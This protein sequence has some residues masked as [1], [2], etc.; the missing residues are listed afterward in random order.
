MRVGDSYSGQVFELN[1]DTLPK[2]VPCCEMGLSKTV[3]VPCCEM[4]LSKTVDGALLPGGL[5]LGLKDGNTGPS[6]SAKPK[7]IG[8]T[9][10]TISI[11]DIGPKEMNFLID[12]HS[13]EQK[14]KEGPSFKLYQKQKLALDLLAF[15]DA[16]SSTSGVF[17]G[18]DKDPRPKAPAPTS[19]SSPK[20]LPPE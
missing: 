11:F 1:S 10:E 15:S 6:T 19:S 13:I 14:A 18:R 20:C 5:V 8:N 3:D 12:V 16:S 7:D 2:T 9:E 17:D 4:G